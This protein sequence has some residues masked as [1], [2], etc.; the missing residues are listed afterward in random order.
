[1]ERV[2]TK[3]QTLANIETMKISTVLSLKKWPDAMTQSVKR[4]RKVEK[5]LIRNEIFLIITAT[6]RLIQKLETQKI[7]TETGMTLVISIN[8][9]TGVNGPDLVR[10]MSTV[11]KEG[12]KTMKKHEMIAAR[13]TSRKH[14]KVKSKIMPPRLGTNQEITSVHSGRKSMIWKSIH[15]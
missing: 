6:N 5:S 12:G 10:N 14:T 3:T 15:K 8:G 4:H 13:I 9:V 2:K 7:S 11:I 1:M